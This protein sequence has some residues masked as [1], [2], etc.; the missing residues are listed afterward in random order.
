MGTADG[1]WSR[2]ANALSWQRTGVV[3]AITA[4]A[5]V[6][7]LAQPIDV[8]FWSFADI[9]RAWL[10]YTAELLL[11]ASTIALAFTL[12]D[13]ALPPEGIWRWLVLVFVILFASVA[14]TYVALTIETFGPMPPLETIVRESFRWSILGSFVAGVVALNRRV[15]RTYAEAR[16]ADEARAGLIREEAEQQLQLLQAQIEPHFLF[17]TLANLRRLYRTQPQT[18]VQMIESL[19]RYLSAALPRIRHRGTTLAGEIELI[20]AYLALFEVR[21][22]KRLRF[23]IEVE[24]KLQSLPLPPL[25]L[26]TL[27]ENA[28]KH[29]I[30]PSEAGGRI[31]VVARASANCIQL[32]VLDDGVGF[33]LAPSSGTGVGLVNVRRQLAARYGSRASLSVEQREPNGVKA[34]LRIPLAESDGAPA[35]EP[36]GIARN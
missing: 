25:L 34:T 11:I 9:A 1:Y 13:E 17:N 19:K 26:M 6:Q 4:V 10:A 27:V 20:R 35:A 14:G 31:D 23:H 29:G 15:T 7:I 5:S 28:V 36:N 33:F 24:P 16:N 21:L 8:D 12:A 2:V 18:G 3:A 30:A 32:D 22:G